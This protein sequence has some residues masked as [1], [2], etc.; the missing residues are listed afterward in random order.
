M[1]NV[2]DGQQSSGC[3]SGG[4]TQHVASSAFKIETT[5]VSSKG[6]AGMMTLRDFSMIW[7]L[8]AAG[9]TG[10]DSSLA[11]SKWLAGSSI[12]TS[13][14]NGLLDRETEFSINTV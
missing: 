13:C 6:L 12:S 5:S 11:G 14:T 7:E 3:V 9:S 2:G 1:T 4:A 8:S 10:E